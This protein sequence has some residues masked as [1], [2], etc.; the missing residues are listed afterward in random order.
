MQ[1][2]HAHAFRPQG[3][4]AVRG[5]AAR[6]RTSAM[7][8]GGRRADRRWRSRAGARVDGRHALPAADVRG[9]AAGGRARDARAD[10]AARA[11]ST[12]SL[13]RGRPG[14]R[15][16]R[17]RRR[18]AGRP[19]RRRL[20][21]GRPGDP[22]LRP[23]PAVGGHC[24][25]AYVDRQY[26]LHAGAEPGPL[27]NPIAWQ[28]DLDGYQV[29]VFLHERGIF[30]V[31]LVRPDRSTGACCRCGTRP[32][33]RRPAGRSR[34]WPRG[35]TR[36]ASRPITP[37][38]PGGTLLNGYRGQRGRTASWRCP[39]CCSSA[40]PSAPRRPNF[41]RGIATSLMQVTEVLRLIDEHGERPR[42]GRRAVR[43]LVRGADAAVGRGPRAH[44]R[45]DRAGAG[46]ARTSTCR[47]ALPSDLVLAA[48]AGDPAIGA[49]LGPYL[50]M[51]GLPSCLDRG[52]AAR[53]GGVRDRLAP[54]V[55]R[56][57]RRRAELGELVSG[58][59]PGIIERERPVPGTLRRDALVE[60]CLSLPGSEPTYP[61][62]EQILVLKVGGKIFALVDLTDRHG[63]SL[64][65]DPASRRAPGLPAPAGHAGL[66]PGQAAL[67]HASAS[68]TRCPRRCSSTSSRSPTSS[69]S[70][71]CR[72][73]CD[74]SRPHRSPERAPAATRRLAAGSAAHAVRVIGRTRSVC[75]PADRGRPCT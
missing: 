38:L 74:R 73:G 25:I 67:D 49:A 43:R 35:P 61:F 23:P 32:R 47:S 4:D 6:R 5:R 1:F 10:A 27:P 62:G 50:M 63:V 31:L 55:R 3:V 14:R 39:G 52:R 64:K 9:G 44:G 71:G 66:P 2:H 29:I 45:V 18:A 30:S 59:E 54:A 40:T 60:H 68:P 33:S 69:W 65:A 20:R 34:G 17:R 48:A 41:G 13:Q 53:P 70:P 8:D 72:S 22:G 19:G 36:S 11:T 42:R 75:S 58:S 7:L 24:G 37:V 56:R 57:A 16:A 12:R 26:Q 28:A 21:P 46:P 15:A 51:T